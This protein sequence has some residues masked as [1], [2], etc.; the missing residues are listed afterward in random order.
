MAYI[1]TAPRL[2]GEH[3]YCAHW[4]SNP[5]PFSDNHCKLIHSAKCGSTLG[6]ASIKGYSVG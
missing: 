1:S 3:I 5:R 2:Y 6:L 4:D